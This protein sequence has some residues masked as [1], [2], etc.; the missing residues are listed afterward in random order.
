MSDETGQRANLG[1]GASL[2]LLAVIAVSWGLTWPVNKAMLAYTSPVWAV[3]VRYVVASSVLLLLTA[4]LGRLKLPPRQDWPVVVSVS[5]LHMVAFGVLCSVG[6]K[7][8]PAGRSVLLAYTT[9]FWVFPLAR[10]VL[11]ER[12]TAARLLAF[13]SGITG[14]LLL[15]NPL[16][17]DWGDA[18]VV[19]GH[20][21]ILLAA[22][23]WACSIVYVRRHRWASVPFDLLIWQAML[24]MVMTGVLGHVL[25]GPL[26]IEINTRLVLLALYGGGIGTALAFWALNT[27][28]RV[29]PATTT[30]LGLLG[31]PL[32]GVTCSILTLG[33][34]FD[35][36]SVAALA[37]IV[38]GIAIGTLGGRGGK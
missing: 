27:V 2:A 35:A 14:L 11:G 21:L 13:A 31:V 7:S 28:N 30:S 36:T 3:F 37:L 4:A 19:R 8:V 18:N 25:E 12:M 9:P 16:S 38:G 32:F 23:L 10:L 33:E 26:R 20:A 1:R 24:A 5:L 22:V 34:A 15:V 17:L 29:L 6:L